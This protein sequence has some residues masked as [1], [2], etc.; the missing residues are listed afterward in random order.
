MLEILGHNVGVAL[1]IPGCHNSIIE[2]AR[3]LMR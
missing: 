2:G 1:P 3:T